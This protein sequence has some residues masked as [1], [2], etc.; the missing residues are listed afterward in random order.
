[1]SVTKIEVLFFL[2]PGRKAAH[3]S[4]RQTSCCLYAPCWSLGGKTLS[5][6]KGNILYSPVTFPGL[7][8]EAGD[9]PLPVF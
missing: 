7:H 9:S 4:F 3:G 8:E 1:M 6:G 2:A 5:T